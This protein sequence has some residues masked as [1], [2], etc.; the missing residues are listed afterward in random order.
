M[1]NICKTIPTQLISHQL[2]CANILVCKATEP[3]RFA[4][5]ANNVMNIPVYLCKG[6]W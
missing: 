3:P 4:V 5:L 6:N 1:I 2:D